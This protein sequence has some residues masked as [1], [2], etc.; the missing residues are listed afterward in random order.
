M[1]VRSRFAR[2]VAGDGGSGEAN[3][4]SVPTRLAGTIAVLVPLNAGEKLDAALVGNRAPANALVV[5]ADFDSRKS[6]PVFDER[7]PGLKIPDD[8]RLDEMAA[9]SENWLVLIGDGSEQPRHDSSGWRAAMTLAAL[10]ALHR[11]SPL[12]C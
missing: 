8:I 11:S 3:V 7:I 2:V 4:S 1:K 12:K 5:Q 10:D 9:L 6:W